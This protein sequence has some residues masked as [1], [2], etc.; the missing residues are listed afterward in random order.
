MSQTMKTVTTVGVPAK[1]RTEHLPNINLEH[2]LSLDQSSDTMCL[3]NFTEQGFHLFM[4][5]NVLHGLGNN[6]WARLAIKILVSQSV[7]QPASRFVGPSATR[8]IYTQRTN[9]SY[10]L[11]IKNSWCNLD[12]LNVALKLSLGNT[13][14]FHKVLLLHI[15][16]IP[17]YS[18]CIICLLLLHVTY[19]TCHAWQNESCMR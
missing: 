9:H 1:A 12:H 7:S 5:V 3:Y 17:T 4:S 11:H 16:S 14:Y 18:G 10:N 2:S 6:H 13:T 15:R 19:N 8:S